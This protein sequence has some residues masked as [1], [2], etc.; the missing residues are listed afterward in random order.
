MKFDNSFCLRILIRMIGHTQIRFNRNDIY[1]IFSSWTYYLVWSAI[2]AQV[3]F[4][5]RIVNVFIRFLLLSFNWSKENNWFPLVDHIFDDCEITVLS[6]NPFGF[7]VRTNVLSVKNSNLCLHLQRDRG[8]GP[9]RV[10]RGG[11]D[12]RLISSLI[13]KGNLLRPCHSNIEF[14][15]RCFQTLL[16]DFLLSK[17]LQVS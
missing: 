17:M 6:D 11:S 14:A 4:L 12:G 7:H 2:P 13:S 10:V 16:M 9:Y 1:E 5:C 15:V 8:M 3:K